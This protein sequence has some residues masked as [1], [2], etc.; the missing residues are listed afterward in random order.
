MITAAQSDIGASVK[1][2]GDSEWL[3]KGDNPADTVTIGV[4]TGKDAEWID[5]L[6]AGYSRPLNYKSYDLDPAV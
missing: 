5:V 2:A 4:V 1:L 3:G 6:W